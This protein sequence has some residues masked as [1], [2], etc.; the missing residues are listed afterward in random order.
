MFCLDDG[1]RLVDGPG[2]ND[3]TTVLMSAADASSERATR[4]FGEGT[5]TNEIPLTAS[6]SG[7]RVAFGVAGVLLLA[8][9]LAWVGYSLYS[10]S[11][12]RQIDSI[13]VMPFVNTGGNPEMEYLS[14][15]ITESLINSLSQIPVLSVKARSSVFTYKGKDVT[16]QQV[17]K[18]LAVQAVLNGRVQ[19]R[20]EQMILYVELVDARTGNQIWGEQYTRKLTDLVQLQSEIASDVS[21]KLRAKLTGEEQQRVAKNSTE[22]TEAY[23]LYLRGRYHWNKRKPDDIRKS[24]TYFQQAIDK[25]P[26]YGQAYAA[27]A[28]AYILIPNYR[29]APS[30]EFYPK[31]RAGNSE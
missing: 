27:L 30:E 19:Q 9:L 7:N 12:G 2:L 13:A 31:A 11:S 28:E 17:A 16:P 22:D 15:G 26:T 24:V 10:R 21:G 20:G 6:R 4:T 18:D 8:V 1:A 3:A 29:L 23:Q 5:S 25:D 14:D